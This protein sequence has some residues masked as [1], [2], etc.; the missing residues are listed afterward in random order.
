MTA[1]LRD[2]NLNSYEAI[3][4][5]FKSI[6]D[7]SDK[8]HTSLTNDSHQFD[9]ALNQL[10]VD[11]DTTYCVTKY[12]MKDIENIIN[13]LERITMTLAKAITNL[14]DLTQTLDTIVIDKQDDTA[15][16][17]NSFKQ[18]I[19]QIQKNINTLNKSITSYLSH[20]TYFT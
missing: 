6:M 18:L 16:V 7:I 5:N 14:E 3:D 8:V 4:K 13:E 19:I 20:L 12:H 11:F 10:G 17:V 9:S 1:R 15:K 2:M